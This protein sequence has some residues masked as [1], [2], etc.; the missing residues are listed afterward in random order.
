M[1]AAD[2]L[3]LLHELAD[4]ADSIST[5][6]FRAGGLQI[7]TK[8]DRSLV[9]RADLEVESS[10]REFMARV[11]PD[12][13]IFGEEQGEMQGTNAMRLII[14]PIDAT[15]NFARG[16][17]LFAT[18][19]ALE[20]SGEVVAG[21]VSAPALHQRW[22]A[23][24]GAGAWSGSRRLQVSAVR[25]LADAQVFHGSLAGGEAVPA[26]ARIPG[27]LAKTWRQRGFGDFYQHVLVAEGCGEIAIDPLVHPWDIAPLSILVHEAG[28][29]ATTIGG[30]RTIYAGSLISTNGLLHDRALQEFSG[31]MTAHSAAVP[32]E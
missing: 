21:L 32:P 8:P 23:A 2:W 20:Q 29:K 26:T 24:R 22:H 19:L 9:T 18:L 30:E 10:I 28:G 15:A 13:G 16:I 12:F 3:P 31:L 14:D 11:H 25:E 27:L 6:Y 4:R 17:P 5:K 7:Q 1:N